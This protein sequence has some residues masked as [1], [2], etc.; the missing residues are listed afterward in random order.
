MLTIHRERWS[1][2][3]AQIRHLC[4]MV[5]EIVEK[6][7]YGLPLDFDSD[8]YQR[9]EDEDQ[10]HCLVM[11]KNGIPIGFHWMVMYPMA[12]F[13]GYKQAGTDAIFVHPNYRKYSQKLIQFSE[14][15]A[16]DNG[17]IAW[18][19]ATLD[20]EYRGVLWERKGF[21]KAETIFIKVIK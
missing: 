5:H 11:R 7:L 12:R 3:I 14:K 20:P 9:S 15:Y 6:E 13:K 4:E 18:A 8:L 17:C 16:Q 21:K 1:D 10:F 2:C 19:I